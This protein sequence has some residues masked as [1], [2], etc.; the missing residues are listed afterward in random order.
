MQYKENLGIYRN[1]NLC[2][3][4]YARGINNMQYQ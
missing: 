4:W 1:I 3:A 2:V